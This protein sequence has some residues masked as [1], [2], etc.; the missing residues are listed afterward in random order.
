MS[1]KNSIEE[2]KDLFNQEQATIEDHTVYSGRR[3]SNLY[4]ICSHGEKHTTSL[5][6]WQKG[7]RC[8]CHRKYKQ[9]LEHYK[10]AEEL[11][12]RYEAKIITSFEEYL[13]VS[14]PIK[15]LNI[16]GEEQNISLNNLNVCDKFFDFKKEINALV[17][18]N[19]KQTDIAR[20]FN[21]TQHVI[22]M[23]LRL[24]GINNSNGNRFK[25]ITIPKEDL[26]IMYWVEK[27]HPVVIAEKYN[28]SIQTVV[29]NMQENA[30]PLRTKSESRMAELNPIYNIGHTEEAREKMSAAYLKGRKV[31]FHANKWGTCSKYV[32]PNQGVITLRSTWEVKTADFLTELGYNWLYEHKTFKLSNGISYTPDFYIPAE[33]LYIEVKGRIN[34][35]ALNKLDLFK[36]LEYKVLLWDAEELLK[37]GIIHNSGITELNRKYKN[38]IVHRGL[39]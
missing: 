26:Y 34:A 5:A 39:Y 25:E 38:A 23:C 31:G 13:N 11:L 32:S 33:D 37:R 9:N 2:I 6:N 30:M 8:P 27:K 7:V 3:D 24:W 4:Y 10:K 35:Y 21:T 18:D 12:S 19:L 16:A 36:A 28:C 15:F 1:K 29:R 20:K 17:L 22:S 14:T